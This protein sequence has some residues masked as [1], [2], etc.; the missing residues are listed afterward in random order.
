M[1]FK[2]ETHPQPKKIPFLILFFAPVYFVVKFSIYV[3]LF[4]FTLY[5]CM[6]KD[7]RT[8][9]AFVSLLIFKV[10]FQRLLIRTI[11][12]QSQRIAIINYLKSP[13]K[14]QSSKEKAEKIRKY[15]FSKN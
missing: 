15:L 4:Y 12:Y 14:M 13:K 6:E 9:Y 10:M 8:L 7:I 2:E 1:R 5:G 11:N 3:D